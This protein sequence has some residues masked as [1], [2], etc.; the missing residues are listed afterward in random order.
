MMRTLSRYGKYKQWRC[1]WS[2][3]IWKQF[4]ITA[5]N[6][7]KLSEDIYRTSSIN[8]CLISSRGDCCHALGFNDEKR[9]I[10]IYRDL[11]RI[12]QEIRC[13][14]QL[15]KK[16]WGARPSYRARSGK[17]V[18]G[19]PDG[20]RWFAANRPIQI[21]GRWCHW[22]KTAVPGCRHVSVHIARMGIVHLR[23]SAS[24]LWI[25]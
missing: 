22:T 9:E 14:L 21:W 6:M 12:A 25:K 7:L 16:R 10:E 1:G 8:C 4:Q 13:C 18:Y 23:F 2:I 11:M 17:G 24:V 20:R 15:S 19:C 3:W 5:N